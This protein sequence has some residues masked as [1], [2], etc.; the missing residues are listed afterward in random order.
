MSVTPVFSCKAPDST[1]EMVKLNSK[2]YSSKFSAGYC[3]GMS[4]DWAKTTLTM[5]E[6]KTLGMLHRWEWPI[7]QSAYLQ[8]GN[9]SPTGGD[10]IGAIEG[11]GLTVTNADAP[12]YKGNEI[13]FNKDFNVLAQQLAT[14]VGTYIMFLAGLPKKGSH[15]FGFRRLGAVNFSVAEWFDPND[16]LMRVTT[17]AEWAPYIA[18]MLQYGYSGNETSHGKLDEFCIIAQ[19]EKTIVSSQPTQAQGMGTANFAATKRAF[20]KRPVT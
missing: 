19:V 10:A 5:G 9:T 12:G 11:N 7:I 1:G 13:P 3:L 14:R 4:I 17:Q 20:T 16:C 6:V 18:G 8:A 15:F 2:I